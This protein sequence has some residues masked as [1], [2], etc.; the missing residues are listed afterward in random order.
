MSLFE[1]DEYQWRETYFILFRDE[2]HPSANDVRKTLHK[3]NARYLIRD[4]KADEEGRFESLTLESPDDYAAMDIT[5]VRGDEVTE[6][7]AE[8]VKD[9]LKSATTAEQKKQIRELTEYRCRFDV[10]HFEQLLFVGRDEESDEDEYMDPGALL[11]VMER[12][13]GLCQGIIVDPQANVIL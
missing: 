2:K 8:L 6:Q 13:A 1:N 7:T 9:L 4:V 5:L 10:Y 3:L 12:I 11:S